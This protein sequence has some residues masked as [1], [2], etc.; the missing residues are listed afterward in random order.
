MAADT[1]AM[2]IQ[3]EVNPD[4][5]DAYGLTIQQVAAALREQGAQSI[6]DQIRATESVL[7]DF[8]E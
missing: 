3:V 7:A 5:L 6:L 1:T 4:L 2:F 8:T